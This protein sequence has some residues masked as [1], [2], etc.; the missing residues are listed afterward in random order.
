MFVDFVYG[1]R[2]NGYVECGSRKRE[3]KK[4]YRRDA[5]FLFLFVRDYFKMGANRKKKV[6]KL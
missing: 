1:R 2:V 3:R 4:G 6:E 5:S